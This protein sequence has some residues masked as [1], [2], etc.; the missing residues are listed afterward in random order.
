M[1]T[2]QQTRISDENTILIQIFAQALRSAGPTLTNKLQDEIPVHA[3][4]FLAP[5]R[6]ASC[7]AST[8]ARL[9]LPVFVYNRR[10]QA[11]KV[12]WPAVTEGDSSRTLLFTTTL[13]N[14]TSLSVTLSQLLRVH[15]SGSDTVSNFMQT[16]LFASR[17]WRM[18]GLMTGRSRLIIAWLKICCM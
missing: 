18:A 1:I 7:A 16:Q 13:A 12:D 17:S 14:T 5:A 6:C 4:P 10:D 11:S 9:M 2:Q 15:M 8:D 3:L